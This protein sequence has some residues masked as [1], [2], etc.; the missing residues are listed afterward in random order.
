[1]SWFMH[2]RKAALCAAFSN[3]LGISRRLFFTNDNR[4]VQVHFPKWTWPSPRNKL[5]T[6]SRRGRR[7]R[8]SSWQKKR[9]IE[10][11]KICQR[12]HSG[13]MTSN[14]RKWAE[15]GLTRATAVPWVCRNASCVTKMTVSESSYT[16]RLQRLMS[17]SQNHSSDWRPTQFG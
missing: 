9:L 11:H 5:P 2:G 15:R 10:V 3:P 4:Q 13:K 1:M 7:L 6:G 12:Q 17:T 8:V 16:Y 14:V